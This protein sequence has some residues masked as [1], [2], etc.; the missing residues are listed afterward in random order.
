MRRTI[1]YLS[2]V[3][4]LILLACTIPAGI[5]SAE[6]NMPYYVIVDCSNN[7]TTV[8]SAQ[9]Q[10]IVR[11]MICSTGTARTPTVQGTFTMPEKWKETD[12]TEWSPLIEGYGKYASRIKGS[13]LFHSFM[14]DEPDESAINWESYAAMGTSASHGCIRLYLDDAKWIMNNCLPGTKVKIYT[15][16]EPDEYI[17]VRLYEQT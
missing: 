1:R 15:G 6:Y 9:D 14:Y 7:I 4:T 13:Y 8:Y 11:Q 17:K 12:R 3:I 10:S 2:L 5:A 16:E